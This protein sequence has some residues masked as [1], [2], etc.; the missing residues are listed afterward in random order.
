MGCLDNGVE[1]VDVHVISKQEESSSVIKEI[2]RQ[3]DMLKAEVLAREVDL[4][5]ARLEMMTLILE[6]EESRKLIAV[7]PSTNILQGVSVESVGLFPSSKESFVASNR[8]S[9]SSDAVHLAALQALREDSRFG[10]LDAW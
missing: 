10:V 8:P 5:L 7:V 9:A 2:Q 6:I 4:E 1:L 3:N